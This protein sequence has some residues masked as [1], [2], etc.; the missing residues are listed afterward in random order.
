MCIRPIAMRSPRKLPRLN[1][2]GVILAIL[3]SLA[4]QEVVIDIISGE[5]NDE[6]VVNMIIFSI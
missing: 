5:P 6:I 2:N 4:A 3:S 1:G